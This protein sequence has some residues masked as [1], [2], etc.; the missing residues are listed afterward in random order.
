[1]RLVIKTRPGSQWT[2]LRD[3]RARLKRAFDEAG[4]TLAYDFANAPTEL[5]LHPAEVTIREAHDEADASA[6]PTVGDES[7]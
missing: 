2:V 7:G 1:M 6:G 4:I 5:V 3:L